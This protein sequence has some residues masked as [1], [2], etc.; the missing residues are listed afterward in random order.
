MREIIIKVD[1]TINV[2]TLGQSLL[3]LFYLNDGNSKSIKI[4]IAT[5]SKTDKSIESW[6]K[7][8]KSSHPVTIERRITDLQTGNPLKIKPLAYFLY[9]KKE[10]ARDNENKLQSHFS[11]KKH[12]HVNEWFQLTEQDIKDI[13]SSLDK[14]SDIKIIDCYSTHNFWVEQSSHWKFK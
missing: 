13:I 3:Y 14:K 8:A 10:V 7:Y 11:H 5:Y 12:V 1:K 2:D 6:R 4:G 9:D